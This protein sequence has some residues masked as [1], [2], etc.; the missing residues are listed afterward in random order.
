MWIDR[1]CTGLSLPMVIAV[2]IFS[3]GCADLEQGA[4]LDQFSQ[5]SKRISSGSKCA[6]GCI[7][8]QYAVEGGAQYAS[9]VCGSYECACVQENDIYTSCSE[10]E[11][12]SLD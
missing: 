12:E 3:I 10:E 6:P 1:A 9:S 2:S 7:W 5:E 8:S 4:E 11:S